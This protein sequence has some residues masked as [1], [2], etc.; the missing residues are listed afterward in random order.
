MFN[1]NSKK[2]DKVLII[3]TNIRNSKSCTVF[4]VVLLCIVSF[5]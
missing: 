5:G 2:D 4:I 3:I 1:C